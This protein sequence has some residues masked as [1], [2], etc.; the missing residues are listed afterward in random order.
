MCTIADCKYTFNYYFS[1]S[2][3]PIFLFSSRL[4]KH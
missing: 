2:I 1:D 3:L 4:S